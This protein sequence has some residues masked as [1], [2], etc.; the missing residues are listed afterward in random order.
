MSQHVSIKQWPASQRPREKLLAQGAASLS[1]AE[2]LAIFLRTGV[3][4]AS[5]VDLAR[6]LLCEFGGLAAL[7]G[8]GKQQFCRGKGLGEAKYT[9]LQAVMELSKRYLAEQLSRDT[10]F[11]S[12][13]QV[14]SYLVARLAGAEREIFS[15]L[16]LDSQHRLIVCED[17]FFGSIDSAVVHPREVVK[18]S[19]YHNAAA[20]IFA[21]NHPSGVAEPSVADRQITE[22]L[23]SA[24]ALVDVRV[25]DH[26]I[27]VGGKTQSLAELG[28]I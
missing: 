11:S 20:I 10:V 7:L 14:S 16:F 9:Q 22:Q 21:H 25:L 1:D 26:L 24:L 5:A 12:P 4:G 13:E 23:K 27:V 18:R 28:M 2:L 3:A 19:L 8:A 15:A 6:E 17:L